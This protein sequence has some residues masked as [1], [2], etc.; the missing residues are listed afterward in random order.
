MGKFRGITWNNAR[1]GPKI[2]VRRSIDMAELGDFGSITDDTQDL[3]TRGAAHRPDKNG[4]ASATRSHTDLRG[5]AGQYSNV[6][7]T[8]DMGLITDATTTH[9]IWSSTG[10]ITDVVTEAPTGIFSTPSVL[11]PDADFKIVPGT[12]SYGS[13]IGNGSSAWNARRP[14][15]LSIHG[16]NQTSNVSAVSFSAGWN[17]Y[18]STINTLYRIDGDADSPVEYAVYSRQATGIGRNSSTGRAG[19]FAG[20]P[21]IHAWKITIPAG[22]RLYV[23]PGQ[24]SAKENAANYVGHV[25]GTGQIWLYDPDVSTGSTIDGVKVNGILRIVGTNPGRDITTVADSNEGISSVSNF[26]SLNTTW[27][28]V[29]THVAGYSGGSV[30]QST[31]RSVGGFA[32]TSGNVS[33]YHEDYIEPMID[34]TGYSTTWATDSSAEEGTNYYQVDGLDRI[35]QNSGKH[36][37]FDF[38]KYE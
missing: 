14:L 20:I 34:F 36:G 19:R 31:Q 6:V 13:G 1:F 4:S 5:I 25:G 15:G 28:D 32:K 22:G 3:P 30:G 10:A 12:S 24:A 2:Q 11:T 8:Q 38:Q 33:Q 37:F 7:D 26:M 18:D 17:N 23:I 21:Y 29:N 9:R 16:D 27:G 35:S